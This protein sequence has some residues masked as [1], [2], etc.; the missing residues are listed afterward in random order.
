MR[1]LLASWEY[2]PI[3]EGGLARHVR[4]L[5]E[6][7]AAVGVEVHVLTRGGHRLATR[8]ER[9]GVIV[10]RLA[11]GSSYPR[12]VRAFV[13]W[14]QEMNAEIAQRG[15]KLVAELEFDLQEILETVLTDERL[16]AQLVAEAREH[17]LRFDW[18]EVA[19]QTAA[20]YA[21][22][23]ASQPGSVAPAAP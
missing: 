22:A 14:V 2:P 23:V 10:H 13:H 11:G 12:D 18:G 5:S 17:V 19:R 9:H 6:Q 1:V 21:R 16:G 3:I 15:G 20:L 8:E 4:K 7:L